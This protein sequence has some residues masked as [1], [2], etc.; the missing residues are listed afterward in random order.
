[1]FSVRRLWA[2][3]RKELRH[4]TRDSRI[5]FL[6]T[7]SPAF[8]L[9]ILSYIFAFDV[10]EVGLLWLDRDR[11]AATREMLSVLT[12]DGT[13]VVTAAPENYRELEDLLREGAGE[14]AVVLPPGFQADLL[15]RR[16][17]S[18]QVVVDGTD[19]ISASQAL[20]NLAARLAA[21]GAR[22]T[23]RVSPVDLRTRAWYNGDLKSLWSMVPGLLGI[24]LTLPAL[25]LTLAVTREGETGTL[26]A[27]YATPVRGAEYLLGKL[28]AYVASALVSALLAAGVAVLWFGVPF[29]G[30]VR[31]FLLLT[32]DYCLATMGICLLVARFMR[33]QQTAMLLVLLIFFVPGF[34]IAGLI[35]PV[36]TSSLFGRVSSNLLPTTH[37][38]VIAR[39]VL[40]KGA[41]LSELGSH[42]VALLAIGSASTLLS[43]LLF[44]KR[45]A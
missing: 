34:F 27:L 8:L 38:I 9:L 37:F 3:T 44:R 35:S 15:A 16:G 1:M 21:F 14:A 31:L 4:I 42:A 26:E 29:R 39:A 28:I 23:G 41:G 25:A 32:A 19:A 24:V 10:T 11:S 40:L 33:S 30:D 6:V 13:F 22:G 20:G 45:L 7:I 18:V 12:A 2:I 36:N 43:L 17:A 5:F